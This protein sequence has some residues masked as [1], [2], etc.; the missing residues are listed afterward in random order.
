MLVGNGVKM[1]NIVKTSSIGF[2][3][4][5]NLKILF[6]D[7]HVYFSCNPITIELQLK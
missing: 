1:L 3:M 4:R 5:E 6:G 2:E 7:K